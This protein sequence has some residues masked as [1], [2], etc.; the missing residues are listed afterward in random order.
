[1]IKDPLDS[2]ILYIT[3]AVLESVEFHTEEENG[4]ILGVF[5][6]VYNST[7]DTET[8]KITIPRATI[9]LLD[10]RDIISISTRYPGFEYDRIPLVNP[11]AYADLF[12]TRIRLDYDE[13]MKSAII[14][15][16]IPKPKKMTVEEI[17][18]ALG[19]KV[20]IISNE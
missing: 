10:P 20:E 6:L 13:D 17:E 7:T 18:E 8:R 2:C 19:Y 4:R 14:V 11:I 5:R 9:P 12:G 1:M 15:E 3:D 16:D